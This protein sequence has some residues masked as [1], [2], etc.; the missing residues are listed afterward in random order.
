MTHQ[1]RAELITNSIQT[2][3]AYQLREA[4]INALDEALDVI[5]GVKE[6]YDALLG[7]PEAWN[8]YMHSHGERFMKLNAKRQSLR[9]K[10]HLLSSIV[11]DIYRLR[12][13]S[14]I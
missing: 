12:Y 4:R 3:I 6:G 8:I 11:G 9:E 5:N 14:Q 13:N 10:S 2:E 1:E 7:S